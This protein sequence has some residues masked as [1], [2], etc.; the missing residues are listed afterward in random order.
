M[1]L[2]TGLAVTVVLGADGSSNNAAFAGLTSHD[3]RRQL[4]RQSQYA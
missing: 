2:A 4:H 3:T 1:E